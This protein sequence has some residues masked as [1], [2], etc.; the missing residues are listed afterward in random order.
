MKASFGRQHTQKAGKGENTNLSCS[1]TFRKTKQK[2][3]VYCQAGA[4]WIKTHK[5]KNSAVRGKRK[6]GADIT[7]YSEN[8]YKDGWKVFLSSRKLGKIKEVAAILN[9]KRAVQNS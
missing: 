8:P 4:C 9:A 7:I 3:S 2:P 5:P 1:A 6:H